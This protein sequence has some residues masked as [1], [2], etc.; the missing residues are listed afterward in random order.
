[1]I[2]MTG[3]LDIGDDFTP[4][5]GLLQEKGEETRLI[6]QSLANFP[7]IA[8]ASSPR[9]SQNAA[10]ASIFSPVANDCGFISRRPSLLGFEAFPTIHREGRNR[11]QEKL[12]DDES[13]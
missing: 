10:S 6:P 9:S 3:F 5:W 8:A 4:V 2:K 7:K 11:H 12:A 1:M 13:H